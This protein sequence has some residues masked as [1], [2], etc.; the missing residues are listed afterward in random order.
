M[1]QEDPA[2][3]SMIHFIVDPDRISIHIQIVF[4]NF[5]C[6]IIPQRLDYLSYFHAGETNH[7]FHPRFVV[8]IP[9]ALYH[10]DPDSAGG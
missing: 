3:N 9:S 5:R 8:P 2:A 4:S 7:I 10:H 6:A 1:V